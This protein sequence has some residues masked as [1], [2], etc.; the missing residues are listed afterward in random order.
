MG[1]V[2]RKFWAAHHITGDYRR[3]GPHADCGSGLMRRFGDTFRQCAPRPTTRPWRQLIGALALAAVGAFFIWRSMADLPFGTIDNPGPGVTPLTLALPADLVRTL[4]HGRQ[5]ASASTATRADDQTGAE[6][7]AGR[8]AVFVIVGITVAALA[9]GV[10]GYR[11]TILGLLLF[12]PRR[13]RAQ[14]AFD[15]AARELRPRLRQPCP[16]RPRPE[17]L[18]AGGTVGTLTAPA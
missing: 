13:R 11:L 6:P 8:H 14:A 2:L 15:G 1:N 5:R 16:V 9:F 10:L 4:E 18:A 17:G 3:H 7:G 12:Y